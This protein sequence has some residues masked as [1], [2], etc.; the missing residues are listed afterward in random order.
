MAKSK[1]Q[2]ILA[3]AAKYREIAERLQRL[4]DMEMEIAKEM[5]ALRPYLG[6]GKSETPKTPEEGETDAV[7]PGGILKA[8]A[9]KVMEFLSTHPSA[10]R[11]EI[12]IHLRRN[13]VAPSNPDHLS[14]LLSKMKADGQIVQDDTGGWDLQSKSEETA[15]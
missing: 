9:E 15:A 2:E 6:S 14:P 5:D 12:F 4:A 3:Q 11:G 1:H 10:K 7:R 13:G 8:R